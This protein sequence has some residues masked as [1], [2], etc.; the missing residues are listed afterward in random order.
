[1]RAVLAEW[2]MHVN[3]E[4]LLKRDTYHVSI[5][6]ADLYFTRLPNIQKADLQL[7]GAAAM[8]I[9]AKLEEQQPLPVSKFA[10][11]TNGRYT[12]NTILDMETKICKVLKWQLNPPTIY[13]WANRI[14]L[15]WDTYL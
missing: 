2:M 12:P 10:A 6:L 8:Y 11:S 15:Q 5:V 7:V 14:M 9:A 3:S 4:Y 13:M 1:M